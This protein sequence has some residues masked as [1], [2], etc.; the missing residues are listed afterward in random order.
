MIINI[1][2]TWGQSGD[3]RTT[4]GTPMGSTGWLLKAFNQL[5]LATQSDG[6]LHPYLPLTES[7]PTCSIVFKQGRL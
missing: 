5:P 2:K 6:T 3:G 1:V 7:H 4:N